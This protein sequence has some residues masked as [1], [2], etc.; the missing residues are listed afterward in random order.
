MNFSPENYSLVFQDAMYAM[1]V[2][3]LTGF[4]NQLLGIFLSKSRIRIFIKDLLSS[5]FFTLLLFSYVVSFANYP[6]LRWYHFIAALAGFACFA[7]CFDYIGQTVFSL[8]WATVK[9][10]FSWGF[11]NTKA[12][13][14]NKI[15]EKQLKAEKITQ[16]N[17][18]NSLQNSDI[19]LYN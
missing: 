12:A 11:F 5:L 9:T 19:M 2:G 8:I 4:I 6:T 13:V 18:D 14:G 15:S 16:N 10:V 17:T 3:F 1:C 7:P